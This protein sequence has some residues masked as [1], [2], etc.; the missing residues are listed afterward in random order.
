MRLS[1]M[2]HSK[3]YIHFYGILPT[4]NLFLDTFV[5]EGGEIWKMYFYSF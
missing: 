4:S 5:Q 2:K 3:Y 1:K